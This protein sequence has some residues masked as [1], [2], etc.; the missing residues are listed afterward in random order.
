M[1]DSTNPAVLESFIKEFGDTPSGALG[2]SA[3]GRA[4]E[5]A[6]RDCGTAEGAGTSAS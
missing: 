1:K 4:E 2:E 6:G 3:A 5:A